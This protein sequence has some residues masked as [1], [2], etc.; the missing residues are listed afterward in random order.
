MDIGECY[1]I[2]GLEQGASE[3][4]IKAAYRKLAKQY[5]P[6]KT[7]GDEF[8]ANMFK[9][10]QTAYQTLSDG[11][12]HSTSDHSKYSAPVY[13]DNPVL[14]QLI[15]DYQQAQQHVSDAQYKLK[16]I[17]HSKKTK[18]LSAANLLKVFGLVVLIAVFFYP[19][20]LRSNRQ[21]PLST[22]QNRWVLKT[23]ASLYRKPDK[24]AKVLSNLKPGDQLDS[25]GE[26]QYF[27][28]VRLHS[29]TTKISGYILKNKIGE[30]L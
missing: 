12:G 17:Q 18:Y 20:R 9:K 30:Q 14:K 23:Q 4:E 13:K 21:Q 1:L 5:H 24:K 27:Y 16:S 25:I 2:L 7:Q 26:T 3:E 6:D 15:V 10:I 19:E 22:N 29:G 11:T 28:K 8:L